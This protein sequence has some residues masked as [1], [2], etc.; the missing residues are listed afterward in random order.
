M[1]RARPSSRKPRTS[2][3]DDE[4]PKE[5]SKE[6]AVATP[7]SSRDISQ[8]FA[9]AYADYVQALQQAWMP[10][11]FQQRAM[12]ASRQFADAQEASSAEE[13]RKRA[14]QAYRSYAQAA[15]DTL[16]PQEVQRRTTEAYRDYVQTLKE[17]WSEIQADDLDATTMAAIG[18]T[19]VAGAWSSA[20][21][22]GAIG[23]QWAAAAMGPVAQQQWWWSSAAASQPGSPDAGQGGQGS[24]RGTS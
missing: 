16:T 8:R 13:F 5:D 21:A 24:D 15:Q 18:Q 23:Q 7:G 1:E 17:A 3:R 2:R 4:R 19:I 6:G 14:A 11:E 20:A 12:E 22:I 10:Q 9:R